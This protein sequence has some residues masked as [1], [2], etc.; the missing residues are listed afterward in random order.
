MMLAQ[1]VRDLLVHIDPQFGPIMITS[2]AELVQ[3]FSSSYRVAA[4]LVTAL[5]LIGL[6]LTV[7]G[8]SAFLMYRVQQRTPEI[9]LR[10]ALGSTRGEVTALIARDT[11]RAAIVGALTGLPLALLGA[12]FAASAL[13]G[14]RPWDPLSVLGALLALA[15]VTGITTVIPARRAAGIDPMTALHYE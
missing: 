1:P 3:Y 6:L 14:V 9:G 15:F 12:H 7:V 4:E 2:M 8:L 11:L 10:M 5:G 13:F